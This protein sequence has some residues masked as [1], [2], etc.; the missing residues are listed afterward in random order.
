M[1]KYLPTEYINYSLIVENCYSLYHY[2]VKDEEEENVE[3]P[4]EEDST[5]Q[6]IKYDTYIEPSPPED[7]ENN[8]RSLC[9]SML[10]CT[11]CTKSHEL[12]SIECQ[13]CLMSLFV[14]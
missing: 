3:I 8:G 5:Q 2:P 6:K 10:I 9:Y 14:A 12:E 13:L 11:I 7:I 4:V 1:R